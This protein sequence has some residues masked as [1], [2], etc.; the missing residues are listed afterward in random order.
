MA[1]TDN[2]DAP[3][4]APRAARFGEGPEGKVTRRERGHTGQQHR[5][6]RLVQ[7]LHDVR[8]ELKR[9]SWPTAKHVQNTTIIT[10][11]AVCFFALYL[12]LVDQGM[13]YLIQGLQWLVAKI[14]GWLGFA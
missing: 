2:P 7:F 10:L 11:I 1:E 5:P 13:T 14:A 12:F 4:I 9:V 6:G 8:A 3:I